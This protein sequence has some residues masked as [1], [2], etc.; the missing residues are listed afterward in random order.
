NPNRDNSASALPEAGEKFVPRDPL[1]LLQNGN[2]GQSL[3]ISHVSPRSTPSQSKHK[4]CQA[5]QQHENDQHQPRPRMGCQG[6]GALGLDYTVS[7]FS[8]AQRTGLLVEFFS[9]LLGFKPTFGMENLSCFTVLALS[10]P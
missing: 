7:G 10:S 5:D 2:D 8:P 3:I 9:E 6:P 1:A 4:H